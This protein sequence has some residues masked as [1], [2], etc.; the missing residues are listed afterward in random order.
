MTVI[1]IR[2]HPDSR[3]APVENFTG[4]VYVDELAIAE[5]PSRLRAF[6]VHFTPGARS[7]WHQ[8][9][10]GQIL[11]VTEGEGRVQVQGPAV[12]HIRAGDTVITRPG[13]WHWHGAAPAAFMTHTA[14]QEA[15]DDRCDAYW[16]AHVTDD[17]YLAAPTVAGG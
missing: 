3:R 10:L 1:V 2:T 9:P 12:Q 5:P 6:S 14:I 15:D 16:G 13:E 8:H 17:E 11:H 4:T 7:A